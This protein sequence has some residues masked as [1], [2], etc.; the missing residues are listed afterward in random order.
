M[1]ALIVLTV[2]T[3]AA[4]FWVSSGRAASNVE[5]H[6][7]T[8]FGIV[9]STEFL[10]HPF[11]TTASFAFAGGF[12]ATSLLWSGDLTNFGTGTWASDARV[13]AL[14]PGGS[15]FDFAHSDVGAYFGTIPTAGVYEFPAPF[16]P[17]GSWDFEWYESIVD[18]PGSFDQYHG[19]L[20][21]TFVSDSDSPEDLGALTSGSLLASTGE[22]AAGGLLDSYSFSV[23]APGTIDIT[24]ASDDGPL[25]IDADTEIGLFDSS[26][27]LLAFNDNKA[28]GT[29]SEI[30]GLDLAIGDYT[31]VV[32]SSD[33]NFESVGIGGDIGSLNGGSTFG[34]YGVSLSFL[35]APVPE[36]SSSCLVLCAA[37][38][39]VARRRRSA[40]R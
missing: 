10:G 8:F 5:N 20:L 19:S 18:V 11:N 4:F 16:D 9:D 1:K 13:F 15:G 40:A 23:T 37:L 39:I 7:G 28:V 2:A 21:Y 29:F 38:A 31:L 17:G 35:G 6:E 36:P 14:G 24:T 30:I 32:G 25:I 3:T 22:F 27:K 33:S 26:G 12:T 34:D